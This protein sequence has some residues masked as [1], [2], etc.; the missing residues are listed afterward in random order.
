MWMIFFLFLIV[1]GSRDS[2]N[3]GL[4]QINLISLVHNLR[5]CQLFLGSQFVRHFKTSYPSCHT[6]TKKS[7]R[8]HLANIDNGIGDQ[9][10]CIDQAQMTILTG[11]WISGFP[12]CFLHHGFDVWPFAGSRGPVWDH[13]PG[14][15]ECSRQGCCVW[16][17]SCCACHVSSAQMMENLALSFIHLKCLT[18]FSFCS[19]KDKI[20]TRTL[21]ARMD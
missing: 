4:L 10:F 1:F 20:T 8:Y 18:I 3:D 5:F 9:K 17:G 15:A 6:T 16:H 14:N 12:L 11:N 19:E 2:Y 13:L 21:K 7:L